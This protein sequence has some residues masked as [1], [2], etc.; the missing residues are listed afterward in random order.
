M[1]REILV[2]KEP[3]SCNIR[4]ATFQN[5]VVRLTH[6]AEGQHSY[7]GQRDHVPLN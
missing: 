2:N 1:L 4:Q 6:T 5:D 3:G 7:M